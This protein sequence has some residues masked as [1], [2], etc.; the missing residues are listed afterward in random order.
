MYVGVVI[1]VHLGRLANK[2]IYLMMLGLGEREFTLCTCI[3]ECSVYTFVEFLI[4]GNVSSLY[5]FLDCAA[6]L[7]GVTT[8]GLCHLVD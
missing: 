6:P 1:C 4:V 3:L 5:P 8:V 7:R 2:W